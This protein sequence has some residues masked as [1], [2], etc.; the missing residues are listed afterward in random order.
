MELEIAVQA[1]KVLRP[2][3]QE[4]YHFAENGVKRVS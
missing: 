1:K 2:L 4:P 3:L